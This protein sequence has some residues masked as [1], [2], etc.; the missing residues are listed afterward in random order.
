MTLRSIDLTCALIQQERIKFCKEIAALLKTL[1]II[2]GAKEF[3][4]LIDKVF[5]VLERPGW[6]PS[7]KSFER[8][9]GLNL[10][11]E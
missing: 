2:N 1:E 4:A 6:M 9:T 10:I 5:D 3:H 11:L 8:H 7:R